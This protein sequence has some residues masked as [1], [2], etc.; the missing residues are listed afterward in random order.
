MLTSFSLLAD[1]ALFA[2]GVYFLLLVYRRI[3][4]PEGVDS[5]YDAGYGRW[6]GTYKWLGWGWVVLSLLGLIGSLLSFIGI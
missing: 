2:L 4:K 3:G 5:A 1:L 6:S